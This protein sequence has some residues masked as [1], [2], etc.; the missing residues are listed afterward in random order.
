MICWFLYDIGVRHERVKEV[1]NKKFKFHC[2]PCDKDL[3]CSHQGLKDVKDHCNKPS[4]LQAHSS[5]KKQSRLPSSFTGENSSKR[6]KVLNAEVMVSNF[7]VQHNLSISVAD[8]LDQLFK[9]IFPDSQI[10]SS[11]ACP[12]IKTFCIINKAFQ[13]YYHKQ[14][15]D[16]CKNHPFTVRHDGSNDT[17]VNHRK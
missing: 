13:L 1:K 16:Y 8:H 11:Y 7:I 5:L 14:I 3:S 17:A 2:I 12:K 9:N 10:A 6:K 15:I 4:H